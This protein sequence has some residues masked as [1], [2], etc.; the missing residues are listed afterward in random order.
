MANINMQLFSFL[1]KRQ[2]DI[3]VIIPTPEGN[4][5]ITE[6]AVASKYS[7][8]N[9]L[10]VVY[11]LHGAY[12][13]YNSWL[14][15]SNVERYAQKYQ[16]ALVMASA[17]NS[18]YHNMVHGGAYADF[19][20]KELPSLLKNIFPISTCKEDTYVAGF[21]MGG[22]GAWYLA[23]SEPTLYA[24][25]ASLSGALDIAAL[26]EKDRM[27]PKEAFISWESIVERPEAI[28][29]SRS[30][31]AV[32]FDSA[33]EQGE[34]PDLYQCCGTEDFL[35]AMNIKIRDDL[36]NRGA[37][38]TYEEGSGGHDWNYWDQSIQKV[39]QWLFMKEQKENKS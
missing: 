15:Y 25:S 9:R 19:F 38:L 20:T 12:G 23:L 13:N 14:R 16:C 33:K 29:G 21:S 24:K 39:L 36:K 5:Q 6:A 32:L 8:K 7:F 31:L 37:E 4:E 18:F 11:L 28:K 3:N 2:V 10:P 1:L 17:E 22:Y 34:I 26:Y 27:N 30:E 35:Y